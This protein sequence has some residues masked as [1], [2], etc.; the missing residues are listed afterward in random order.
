MVNYEKK[1]YQSITVKSFLKSI[2]EINVEAYEEFLN[3]P[4]HLACVT[5]VDKLKY[6]VRSAI[7]Y[8]PQILAPT[9]KL[10]YWY[11]RL[12][13]KRFRIYR[14]YMLPSRTHVRVE[15][16]SGN[17]KSVTFTHWG[18]WHIMFSGPRH[19]K[20]AFKEGLRNN[21]YHGI[22]PL[23]RLFGFTLLLDSVKTEFWPIPKRDD[24][25]QWYRIGWMYW[26][27]SISKVRKYPVIIKDSG[28]SGYKVVFEPL[29]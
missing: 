22:H 9:A 23:V 15:Y 29:H 26:A 20:K 13:L 27:I 25:S 24:T 21:G 3:D 8:V 16:K 6:T 1:H 2:Y 14:W 10:G 11:T 7:A 18:W 12:L 17:D 19:W 4:E 28:V 5:T